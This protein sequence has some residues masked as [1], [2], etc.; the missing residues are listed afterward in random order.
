MSQRYI[1]QVIN[2]SDGFG[3][4]G[5][6]TVTRDDGSPHGLPTSQDIFLHRDDCGAP[7][8]ASLTVGFEV[9]ADARRGEGAFR[10][11][12][13]LRIIE[14]ELLP[15]HEPAVPGLVLAS[16]LGGAPALRER[17]PVHA[18][19]KAVPE[20]TVAQV[21]ANKPLP[22][23]PR[24]HETP[25]DP[26]QKKELLNLVL[27]ALF[28]VMADFRADFSVLD[29]TDAELDREV[30]E[31]AENYRAMGLAAEIT[32]MEEQVASFKAIRSAL[33]M[34][35]EENLV[36]PDSIIP[37]RYLPD[38]FMAAPVWY[39]WADEAG[40]KEGASAWVK[41]DPGPPQAAVK[42]FCNL[43]PNQPW[44]D[45]F[46]LW[47][48]RMRTLAQYKGE[49]IPPHVARRM[50]K[51]I[52]LF[53]YIVIATPYHDHASMEWQDPRWLRA[54]DPYVLGFRKGIPFFFVL[55]RFT[56]AGTFPLYQELVADTIEFLRTHQ[57]KVQGFNTAD[58]PFWHHVPVGDAKEWRMMMIAAGEN[59]YRPGNTLGAYLV[60]H[61]KQLLRMFEEG[62]L[63]D[64]LRGEAG[65]VP[66][67]A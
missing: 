56:D 39:F 44:Y 58:H 63:F 30:A 64:W 61:V 46:Q 11:A 66:A 45:T 3:F 21:A 14:P 53:D 29:Y 32:I 59:Y 65:A 24:T 51:A 36:R 35:W 28:P 6:H 43:F 23:I 22:R 48:R 15:I 49:V 37:I 33:A 41:P 2:V 60:G 4:I 17:L 8:G 62:H 57:D 27:R 12:R 25:R 52:P 26:R 54:I 34:I 67:K 40:Q 18:H 10:A 42:Y 20:A 47:N 19:M 13:A 55:A 1:G 9:V 38:L 31:T 16:A 7:I 50:R 5:I